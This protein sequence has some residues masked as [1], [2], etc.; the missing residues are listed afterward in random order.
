MAV[1]SCPSCGYSRNAPDSLIGRKAACPQCKAAASILAGEVPL[2][3]TGANIPGQPP[4]PQAPEAKPGQGLAHFHCPHC[5]FTQDV[6]AALAGKP[7]K[8]PRCKATGQVLPVGA[9]LPQEQAFQ[10]QPPE[11]RPLQATPDEHEVDMADLVLA[12]PPPVSMAPSRPGDMALAGPGRREETGPG[13]RERLLAGGLLPNL[14]AGAVAG[15]ASLLAALCQGA[16]VFSSPALAA[17]LPLG[18]TMALTGAAVLALVFAAKSPTPSLMVGPESSSTAALCLLAPALIPTTMVLASGMPPEVLHPAVIP[19]VACGLAL[20][21]LACGLTLALASR[22]KAGAWLRAVPFAI[23]AGIM[24]AAGYWLL[25]A[26]WGWALG[27]APCLPDLWAALIGGADFSMLEVLQ[28]DACART[29]IGLALGL[30]L[31]LLA[32]RVRHPLT[33]P[34]GAVAAGLAAHLLFWA[35]GLPLDQLAARGW[36]LNMAEPTT[37]FET[38]TDPAHIAWGH[39]LDQ[40]GTMAAL[41][42]IVV[43]GTMLKGA[44]LEPTLGRELDLDR[45]LGALGQANA[46]AAL[47]GGLP[48]ALSLNRSRSARIAGGMS[49]LAGITSGTLCAL[50]L[51]A[52]PRLVPLVP[53]FVLIALPVAHG[54]SLMSRWLVDVRR[55][56]PRTR[57]YFPVLAVFGLIA[58]LGLPAGMGCALALGLGMALSQFGR[59]RVVKHV[60]SGDHFHSNVD[61]AQ[62]QAELLNAQ[63]GSIH[64]LRLQGYLT[65]ASFTLIADQVHGRLAAR[66]LAPARYLILDFSYVS[67]LDSAM[68]LSF[69][70]L[71]DLARDEELVLVFTGLS[72][73]LERFLEE[74]GYAFNESDGSS[75]SFV[76][77]D[78]GLEW[79]ENDLLESAGT[80]DAGGRSLED[81]LARAFPDPALLPEFLSRLEERS[82]PKGQAIF[83]QGDAPDAMYFVRSGWVSVEISIETGR[84]VRL[85]KMG[86]G[87]VFGEMGLFTSDARTA[88]V[89]AAENCQLLRLSTQTLEAMRLSHPELAAAMDKYV[90]SLLAGRLGTANAM[91]RDLLR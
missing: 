45:E 49:P 22:M 57:D 80:L 60:L 48:G 6:P 10:D 68:T 65:Q 27:G 56:L 42:G 74:S 78:H 66:N 31:M 84:K 91:I 21:G 15:L 1:F 28:R 20:A 2:Q 17:A 73:D 69:N 75:Q 37:L 16:L 86:P 7:A 29:G 55:D 11:S 59:L 18:L 39:I 79:C 30:G 71:K 13:F 43:A 4:A 54:L 3:A 51:L 88:S 36:L 25:R 32:R 23:P 53:T 82:L 12:P 52:A 44:V 83:N 24:A 77:L 9:P 90:V 81:L 62:G 64:V 35:K 50:A 85:K 63:G 14:E 61:R 87:T 5:H 89:V 67:G 34:L 26:T 72:F 8:C 38:L 46:L 58:V 33:V 41:I 70:R 47:A 19:T 76:D 40:A